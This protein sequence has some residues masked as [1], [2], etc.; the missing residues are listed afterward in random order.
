MTEKSHRGICVHLSIFLV[1]LL[2][3]LCVHVSAPSRL[4]LQKAEALESGSKRFED[5]EFRQLECESSLEEEKE[6]VSRQLL[7]EKAEYQRSVAK[8]KV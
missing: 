3:C 8:R 2:A 5:L 1:H 7:Q 4:C 6:T